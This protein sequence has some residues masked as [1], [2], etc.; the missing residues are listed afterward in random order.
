MNDWNG[1][2]AATGVPLEIVA[3]MREICAEAITDAKVKER[4]DPSGAILVADTPADFK[5]WLDGQRAL[6]G[7]LIKDANIKLQ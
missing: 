5:K 2:F 1:L 3:R 6:L 4:L 7:K